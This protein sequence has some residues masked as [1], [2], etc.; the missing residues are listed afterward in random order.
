M[1]DKFLSKLSSK[2]TTDTVYNV[3]SKNNQTKKEY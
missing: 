1:F 3:P 2:K